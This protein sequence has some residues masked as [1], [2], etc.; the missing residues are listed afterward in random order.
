MRI[1]DC[2]GLWFLLFL[3][4]A[5]FGQEA[6]LTLTIDE[7]VRMALENNL[8]LK[9]EENKVQVLR[10][11]RDHAWNRFLPS[12]TASATLSRLNEQQKVTTFVP[13]PVPPFLTSQTV[14]IDPW[15]LGLNVQVQLPLALSQLR[16]V[17]QTLVEY[18]NGTLGL[19]QARRRLERDVRKFFYQILAFQ[20]TVRLSRLRAENARQRF[21][22]TEAS[23][24][25]G[26]VPEISA[27][28]SRVAWENTRPGL[29]E[30]ELALDNLLTSF[31][32][33]LGLPIDRPLSLSGSIEAVRFDLELTPERL[34]ALVERRLD[35]RAL[36]ASARSLGTALQLQRDLLLPSL[37]LMFT[38]DPSLN[39]PFNPDSWSEENAWKQRSG[40]FGIT[41]T[42]K[43]D[44]IL[45]GSQNQVAIQNLEDQLRQ[46][47]WNQEQLRLA[48][49]A[50]LLNLFNRI[51][52]Y[53]ESIQT[54]ESNVQLAERA[55]RLA[56]D[57]YRAGTQSL[58]EVQDAEL[59]LQTARL[60]TLNEKINLNNAI[61]DF[62]YALDVG[63]GDLP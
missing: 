5:V 58:L 17:E 59:Q 52:R 28:Q 19:L 43:L 11:N 7:A 27:L 60:Q 36:A 24:R 30:Q 38:M 23:Y 45:P 32:I 31:K 8:G 4:G 47:Q 53:R 21:V 62:V 46:L 29:R 48:G 26:R 63:E 35:V 15:N 61:L 37:V 13:I 42:W 57:G 50:E 33:L 44:S 20:E 51:Q 41:L 49:A 34:Q 39:D 12:V 3:T 18:E 16:A 40:M 55:A 54:L 9:V 1:R 14:T 10:R 22:Q 6:P 56:N 2:K 25:A